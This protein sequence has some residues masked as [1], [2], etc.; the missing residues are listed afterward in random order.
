[1]K[2]RDALIISAA[3]A[4]AVAIPPILR[5]N[6]SA[7]DFE[8]LNGFDGFRR[9][10][11]GTTSSPGDPFF[12]L[13][14]AA[15]AP[16][17]RP[18]CEVLFGNTTFPSQSVPVAVF[19]DVNCPNCA[20]FEARLIRLQQGGAPVELFW[21]Q[22]PLL[23]PRSVWAAKVTL[24]AEMQGAGEDVHLDLMQHVL[25]PG[26]AGAHDVAARHGLDAA[27][28]LADAQGADVQ[29]RLD[30]AINLGAALGIPGTPGSVIGRTLVIG[31]IGQ[32]DLERLIDL[33]LSEPFQGC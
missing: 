14:R 27:K 1:M 17:E 15:P 13:G 29:A 21:H 9:L 3:I 22:L 7:F 16:L 11:R 10:S 32:N 26:P 33:E 18:I 5:R 28:L 23:G 2:R 30:A 31:A 25:R 19:T 12:G 4:V 24:A 8:P 6:A 20:T